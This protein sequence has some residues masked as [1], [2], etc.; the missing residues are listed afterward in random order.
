MIFLR[1]KDVSKKV[2]L[3][4]SSV[5]ALI[6]QG[7]FP[8]PIKLS[9]RTA[10]W[11]DSEIESWIESKIE[12][13]KRSKPE[14]IRKYGKRGYQITQS[15]VEQIGEILYLINVQ[16]ETYEIRTTFTSEETNENIETTFFD[17]SQADIEEKVPDNLDIFQISNNEIEKFEPSKVEPFDSLKT[18][19]LDIETTEL[20]VKKNTT[21]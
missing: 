18:A 9:K 3:P 11:L 14:P 4:K 2:G 6:Q 15:I 13:R 19:I 17:I 12:Q 7:D 8:K 21:S 20:D 10:A 16:N 5:Y 1:I